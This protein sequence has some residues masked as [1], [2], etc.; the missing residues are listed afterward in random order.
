MQ[1]K[2]DAQGTE[3]E[4]LKGTVRAQSETIKKLEPQA[5]LL[6]DARP[7]AR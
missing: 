6:G 7:A 4:G 2:H 1:R 5:S 3:I